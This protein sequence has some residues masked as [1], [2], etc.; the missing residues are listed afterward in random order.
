MKLRKK[1]ELLAP[2]GT[3][4]NAEVA[5]LYGADAIYQGLEGFSLRHGKKSEVDL[6]DIKKTIKLCKKNNKKY[7]LAFNI[8][9]HNEDIRE[10]ETILPK[11]KKLD[12]DAFIVS[13]PGF[14]QILRQQ[15]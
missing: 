15:I 3:Y 12:I 8:F 7:Y 1:P 2:A 13:D 11:L 10:L 14:I 4:E 6:A 5:L 9:A